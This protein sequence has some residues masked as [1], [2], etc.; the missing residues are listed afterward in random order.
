[1]KGP[2]MNNEKSTSERPEL[3]PDPE[4]S[5]K[6]VA[7][8]QTDGAP[9]VER[10]PWWWYAAVLLAALGSG[11]VL[12]ACYFPLSWGLLAWVALVPLV[13]LVRCQP[14]RRLERIWLYLSV[15]L[16]GLTFYYLTLSWMPATNAMMAAGWHGLSFYCSLYYPLAIWLMRLLDRRGWPL[17]LSAGLVWVGLEFVRSFMITGFPWYFVAHTQHIF[18]PVIQIADI[19]GA[20]LVSFLVVLTNGVITI[21]LLALP[22]AR[23]L[24][25]TSLDCTWQTCRVRLLWGTGVAVGAVALTLLYGVWRLGQVHFEPGPTVALLQGNIDQNT[26]NRAG[27]AEAVEGYDEAMKIVADEYLLLCSYTK[28]FPQPIDLIIWPETSFPGQWPEV[29]PAIDIRDLPEHEIQAHN[30]AREVMRRFAN[31]CGSSLLVGIITRYLVAPKKA[32]N[33]S[34][35]LL[36][37][38]NGTTAGRYDKIHRIPFGEYNPLPSLP[39][40][41]Y[42]TPYEPGNEYYAH[43]GN[44]LKRFRLEKWSFGV[45]ICYEDTDPVLARQYVVD[46][47]LAESSWNPFVLLENLR[48]K[49]DGVQLDDGPPADFLVNMSNDGWYA[50]TSEHN[51]HLAIARFR[52]IET[53]RATVRAVNMGISA[54]IDPNGRVLQPGYAPPGTGGFRDN[55]H[56]R[57]D[58][59]EVH[60]WHV[61]GGPAQVPNLP[62]SLWNEFKKRSGVLTATVPIDQRASLYVLWGDWFVYLCS[63]G[64]IVGLLWRR[65]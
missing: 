42:F 26:R 52:S 53:R 55:P 27:R 5:V 34:S 3:P 36:V 39:F 37:R 49:L 22:L 57:K 7:I 65:K 45:I 62:V 4:A 2:L 35:A 23:H 59:D 14:E 41:K 28:N 32:I 56:V 6:A 46:S 58:G 50:G 40:S 38:R 47:R 51:E 48:R 31:Q 64:V 17:P 21:W 12:S 11:V 63:I 43:A 19:G 15:W 9:K 8:V 1:M 30:R 60:F 16:G 10:A 61:N 25:R 44:L 54:I 29:D 18:L 24:L 33:Y 13:A 20:Y